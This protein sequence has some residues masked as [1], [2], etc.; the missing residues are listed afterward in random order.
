[1]L[2][3]RREIQQSDGHVPREVLLGQLFREY[4]TCSQPEG[5]GNR[6]FS[7]QVPPLPRVLLFR[8]KVSE[9]LQGQTLPK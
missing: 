4:L 8:L 7:S 3:S 2:D 9:M 5:N 6:D 1:M